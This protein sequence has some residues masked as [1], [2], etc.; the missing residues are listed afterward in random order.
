MK[1]ESPDWWL[2]EVL[3]R[4]W[5]QM[6]DRLER[7]GLQ[8]RGQILVTGL[9]RDERHAL[10]RSRPRRS[11]GL[12][13]ALKEIMFRR[14]FSAHWVASRTETSARPWHVVRRSQGPLLRH[15]LT[16]GRF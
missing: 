16:G 14:L 7:N 10:G 6:A 5:Q 11:A 13:L 2:A 8:A 3:S 1:T 4:V 9:D 12:A 15:A